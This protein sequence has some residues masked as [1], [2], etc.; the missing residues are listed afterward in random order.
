MNLLPR[1]NI[2]VRGERERDEWNIHV[3]VHSRV[4]RKYRPEGSTLPENRYARGSSE[5][6]SPDPP[7]FMCRAWTNNDGMGEINRYSFWLGHR[8]LSLCARCL[9]RV[10]IKENADTEYA[11]KRYKLLFMS[12][13]DFPHNLPQREVNHCHRANANKLHSKHWYQTLVSIFLV[14][15]HFLHP[16]ACFHCAQWQMALSSTERAGATKI[17]TTLPFTF[18]MIENVFFV[19]NRSLHR[20]MTFFFF[21]N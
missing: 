1:H 14:P 6:A 12:K 20:T 4:H 17:A 2:R 5:K 9:S 8:D 16:A 13:N 11:C 18:A 7:Q 10:L 3:L 15:T 19:V 21:L